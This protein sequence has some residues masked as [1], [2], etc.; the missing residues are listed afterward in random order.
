MAQK[1]KLPAPLYRA[2][3]KL[4][5]S[6]HKITHNPSFTVKEQL[7]YAGGMFGNAMGQ[8]CVY[9]YSSKFN[10]D[11]QMIDPGRLNILETASMILSFL[12]PPVAGSLL[13]RPVRENKKS[14]L[15]F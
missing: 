15:G 8:D 6:L 10:R 14:L 5:A 13:D 2:S 9:T 12:V 11:F 3:E 7:G 4:S 1:G